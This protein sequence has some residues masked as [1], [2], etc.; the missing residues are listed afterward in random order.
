VTDFG[1]ADSYVAETKL[2]IARRVPDAR[3]LDVSH[4]AAPFDLA[5]GALVV[6]RALA[7]LPRGAAL[8]AVVDPGVGTARARVFARVEGVWV[9]GPDNGLLPLHRAQGA[10]QRVRAR[11]LAPAPGV[12]TFDGR[13][14]F[15]PLAA[16]LAAGL[17]P[18]LAGEPVTSF[19][20]WALPAD[21]SFVSD[22]SGSY[23]RGVVVALDRYGN[24]VTN[25]RAPA[26][27]RLAVETPARFAG[28]VRGAYG[29]VARGEPLALVGSS[30]RLE[31]AVREGP[32]GLRAGDEVRVRCAG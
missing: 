6:E 28:P 31:L 11:L 32:S 23:A 27:A 25:V 7:T 10:V 20:S 5:A 14:V 29:E 21:A 30:G 1:A 12:H 26:G 24:A 2:A 4:E 16:L 9:V 19:V 15:G 13:E 22:A 8:A 18:A 3:V 17:A